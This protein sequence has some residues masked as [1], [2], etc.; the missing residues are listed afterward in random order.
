MR[1]PYLHIY[2]T[3]I[4]GASCIGLLTIS[5]VG[6]RLLPS[7]YAISRQDPRLCSAY[8]HSH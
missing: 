1:H 8:P 3:T 2:T 5:P 4:S 7:C 6:G